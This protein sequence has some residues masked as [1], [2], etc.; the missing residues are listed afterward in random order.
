MDRKASLTIVPALSILDQQSFTSRQVGYFVTMTIYRLC[1]Q[2]QTSH[3]DAY[4][5]YR[6]ATNA[7]YD[8]DTN[9]LRVPA[10]TSLE[11]LFF[12]I[13]GKEFELVPNAQIFPS[14]L[15]S[16]INGTSDYLYLM[17]ADGGMPSES[18]LACI[19]GYAFLERFYTVFDALNQVIGFSS[20]QFTKSE[21]N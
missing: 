14:S 19:L 20:T 8:S 12:T 4:D 2:S 10:N 16:S 5:R 18:S 1:A 11:S 21:I 17:V 15:V 3:I 13:A 9:A 6:N 7:T